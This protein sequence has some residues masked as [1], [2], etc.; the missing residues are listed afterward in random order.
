MVG[1][2]PLKKNTTT[3]WQKA[4]Q[5]P[6]PLKDLKGTVIETTCIS[7]LLP[8]GSFNIAMEHGPNRNRW[9]T[10]E[11]S[12][13]I[14]TMAMLVITR[15]YLQTYGRI[16]IYAARPGRDLDGT[17]GVG[18]LFLHLSI[19]L[20]PELVGLSNAANSWPISQ[21]P[22]VQKNWDPRREIRKA[23]HRQCGTAKRRWKDS[24][25][26]FQPIWKIWKTVGMTI[27]NIPIGSM[28][29]IYNMLTLGVY[30]WDPCYHI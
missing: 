17:F 16:C 28:Y 1:H 23:S 11:N 4:S 20:R 25:W 26:W 5:V 22:K 6:F 3:P 13:V 19:E 10:Y 12:M 21:R 27:P 9:F 29:G 8:S 7:Y 30:W 15:W 2:V 14:L 24:G 18:H